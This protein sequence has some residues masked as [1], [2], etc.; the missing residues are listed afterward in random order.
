[1]SWND[2]IPC[3][4]PVYIGNDIY[5]RPHKHWGMNVWA[6]EGLFIK[7]GDRSGCLN[8]FDIFGKPIP[9]NTNLSITAACSKPIVVMQRIY[10]KGDK[11]ISAVLSYPRGLSY[12]EEYFWE[13]YGDGLDDIDRFFGDK[14]EEE[15]E[16]KIKLA[17]TQTP[18]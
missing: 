17:L 7:N 3:T 1:M 13:I 8:G 11:R 14:A 16:V 12:H 9:E 18:S 5:Y 15:M 6:G 4:K 2:W 10:W